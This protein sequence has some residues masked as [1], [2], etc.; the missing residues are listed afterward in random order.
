MVWGTCIASVKL[1]ACVDFSL[2]SCPPQAKGWEG[3]TTSI[4]SCPTYGMVS[5]VVTCTLL[6]CWHVEKVGDLK[7]TVLGNCKL[8]AK[9]VIYTL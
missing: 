3:P 9:H 6:S 4:T 8:L 2:A 7:D 5:M 1:L